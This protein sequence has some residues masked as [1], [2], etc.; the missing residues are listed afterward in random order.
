VK[1]TA[2]AERTIEAKGISLDLVVAVWENP[3]VTYPSNRHPGQHKRVGHGIC[4]AC[5]DSGKVIT[6]FVDRD[7]T[8]LRADQRRDVDAVKWAKRNGLL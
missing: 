1:L 5:D 2:H 6:V 7:T 8:P 4:L 3:S